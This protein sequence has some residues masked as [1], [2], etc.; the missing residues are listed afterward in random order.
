MCRCPISIPAQYG[1]RP[2]DHVM[3]GMFHTA[4][5]DSAPLLT[6][7]RRRGCTAIT[8]TTLGVEAPGFYKEQGYDIAATIDCDP[9]GLTRYYMMKKL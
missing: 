5:L 2:I 3:T 8:L 1:S 9:P 6:H 7:A 4:H